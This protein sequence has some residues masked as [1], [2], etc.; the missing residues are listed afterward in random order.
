MCLQ[1]LSVG[2]FMLGAVREVN[3]F[4]LVISLPHGLSGFVHATDVSV[5][6]TEALREAALREEDEDE[7]EDTDSDD[8]DYVSIFSG[9]DFFDVHIKVRD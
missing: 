8:D 3:D 9:F 6:F 2:M 7:N 1:K 4:E 5:P